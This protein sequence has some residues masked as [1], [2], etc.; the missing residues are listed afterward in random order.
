ME[1]VSAEATVATGDRISNGTSK[2]GVIKKVEV[3]YGSKKTPHS[4]HYHLPAES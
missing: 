2:G 3:G 1:T 4:S